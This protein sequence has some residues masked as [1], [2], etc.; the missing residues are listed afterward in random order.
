MDD[1]KKRGPLMTDKVSQQ[2]ARYVGRRLHTCIYVYAAYYI[3][4]QGIF[5]WYQAVASH[6]LTH[7]VEIHYGRKLPV[8]NMYVLQCTCI[9]F[10]TVRTS[11][12]DM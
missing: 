12:R 6:S 5:H 4:M 7:I 9:C 11:S 10:M 2:E 3:A 1:G 8:Y